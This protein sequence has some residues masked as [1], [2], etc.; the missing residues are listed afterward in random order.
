MDRYI[1]VDAHLQSCTCVVMGSSGRRLKEEVVET[2][3]RA[4]RR[5]VSSVAGGKHICLEEGE[6]SEWLYEIVEPLAQEVVVIQPE[7]RPGQKSDAC[8]AWALAD[9]L[10]T[11][12]AALRVVFK[13]PGQLTALREAVHA[14]LVATQDMARAKNRLRAV[15]RR[16]GIQVRGV[17]LYDATRRHLW[18]EKLPVQRRKLATLF[19]EALD[20]LMAISEQA[21]AWLVDEARRCAA[22][23]LIATT[24]GIK[25]VR[26]S[27]VVA[28]VITPHRFRTKRQFWSYCGLAV[29]THSSS[30]W[31]RDKNGKWVRR[32]VAAPRG[33]NRNRQPVLKDVFNAAAKTV[34]RQMLD[35][36]LALN[37]QRLLEAGT[38]P[39]LARLTVARQIA[40]AVLAMWKKREV[41]DPAKHLPNTTA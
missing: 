4:I 29:V 6:L 11:R 41:Y 27:R 7:K 21:E 40:A 19:S 17:E 35:Q 34:I 25:L 9:L 20:G 15:F 26:A 3:S 12:A 23:K 22:V 24:P 38:K 30:D 36:P 2:S 33:L 18:F 14:Q 8:D 5:F 37:Y 28:K 1:G 16:R 10:R 13:A 39:N 32:Q 31:Q